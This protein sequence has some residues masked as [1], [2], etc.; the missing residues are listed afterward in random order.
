MSGRAKE[1]VKGFLLLCTSN[2]YFATLET[3]K[4]MFGSDFVEANAFRQKLGKWP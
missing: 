1:Y 4:E 3:L 2:A